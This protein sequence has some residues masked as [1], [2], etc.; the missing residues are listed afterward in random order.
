MKQRIINVYEYSELSEKAKGVARDWYYD[1]SCH[2]TWWDSPYEDAANIGLKITSFDC[3]RAN[4][5]TGELINNV[6]Y[7]INQ[8]IKDHG[9]SCETHK[10]ALEYKDKFKQLEVTPPN[11]DDQDWRF[12]EL[13]A[14]YTKEL[15]E[16]YLKMLRDEMEYLS[17]KEYLEE[18]ITCNE[19]EFDEM[20]KRI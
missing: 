9:D 14:E 5:I 7:S 4:D 3:G 8:I 6:D 1:V 16:C 15:L 10:L 19:Y 13:R 2:D 12:D 20:G 11:D 18:C 17:S